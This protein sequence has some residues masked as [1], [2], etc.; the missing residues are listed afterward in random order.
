MK[1]YL[2]LL[3][4][5][6][7]AFSAKAQTSA[8]T[9]TALDSDAQYWCGGSVSV[10]FFPNPNFP[11]INQYYVNGVPLATAYPSLLQ[12]NNL[13]L[14]FGSG[15]NCTSTG[16]GAFAATV[17]DNSQITP[18]GSQWSFSVCALVTGQPCTQIITPVI[19]ASLDISTPIQNA[20]KAPRFNAI[21]G[22]YGYNDT[23]ALTQLIPGAT[24]FNILSSCQRYWNTGTGWVCNAGGGGSIGGGGTANYIPLF[25][26]TGVLLGNSPVSTDGTKLTTTQPYAFS[27]GTVAQSTL[28]NLDGSVT[29]YPEWFGAVGNGTTDDTTAF[30]DTIAACSGICTVQIAAKHYLLSQ[31][32]STP[33]NFRINGAGK[34][35]SELL[36]TSNTALNAGINIDTVSNVE[37]SNLSIVGSSSPATLARGIRV[38][39]ASNV[40]IHDNNISGGGYGATGVNPYSQ[41]HVNFSDNVRIQRNHLFNG[42]GTFTITSNYNNNG[43]VTTRLN[44]SNNV[45]EGNTEVISVG[46][47][48]CQRCSINGNIINQNNQ[49][50][51]TVNDGYAGMYYS[52]AHQTRNLT[53]LTGSGTITVSAAFVSGLTAFPPVGQLVLM[54]VSGVTGGTGTL[55]GLF[56]GV[57]TSSTSASFVSAGAN[58]SGANI[59]AATVT[60]PSG[61]NVAAGNQITNTGGTAIYLQTTFNTTVSSNSLTN[62]DQHEID[63]SLPAGCIGV[64]GPTYG[65][66]SGI[67]LSGNSIDGSGQHGIELASTTGVVISGGS[68]NNTFKNGIYLDS[69]N[70]NFT[71]GDVTLANNSSGVVIT[72][73]DSAGT[74]GA[75]TITNPLFDGLSDY[76]S[77]LVKDIVFGGPTLINCTPGQDGV[78]EVGTN[79]TMNNLKILGGCDI[80]L[81]GS[82]TKINHAEVY[83]YQGSYGAFSVRG[84]QHVRLTDIHA[85]APNAGT[86][87]NGISVIASGGVQSND[88]VVNGATFN[89]VQGS[90]FADGDEPA[91]FTGT[92]T[93]SSTE[94]DYTVLPSGYN[95][96]D[97]ITDASGYLPALTTLT[98]INTGCTTP[99]CFIVSHAATG[100][101]TEFTYL[102]ANH[103]SGTVINNMT[104]E[105][106]PG[107]QSCVLSFGSQ[108]ITFT[109]SSCSNYSNAG[110]QIRGVTT[111]AQAT[112]FTASGGSIPFDLAEQANH[113]V[114]QNSSFTNSS[115]FNMVD[116]TSNP[117]NVYLNNIAT[118]AGCT[119]G[120]AIWNTNAVSYGNIIGYGTGTPTAGC[121]STSAWNFYYQSSGAGRVVWICD[122]VSVA[123]KTFSV[124]STGVASINSNTGAFTFSFSA[125]AGSCSGT[126]CTFTGSGSGGGSV[127]NFIA[128]TGSWPSWLA[129]SV[130]TSTTTPTLSVTAS[131]IPFSALA[132]LSANQVLGAL[133]ATV[134]SGLTLPSCSGAG[135]AINYTLGSGFGCITT[136]AAGVTSYSGDG[137]LISNASSTG[138]VATTLYN[139]A[140]HR[141]WGNNTGSTGAPAYVAIGS[142]DLPSTI[143]SNTSGTASNL[144]GS[145]A[146]PAGT[147]GTTGTVGENDAKLATNAQVYNATNGLFLKKICSGTITLSGTIASGATA[148]VGSVSC[149]G[150]NAGDVVIAIFNGNIF[151]YGGF[152]PST[153]GILAIS[154]VS[155]SGTVTVNAEN[156]TTGSITIGTS[157]APVLNIIGVE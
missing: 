64:N 41:I 129:P 77:T 145:P 82:G 13:P 152:L 39:N 38:W 149:T 45:I 123:W 87:T 52:T 46:L 76:G 88:L 122:P 62:C 89:N 35:V 48:D 94:V 1:K 117:G 49:D 28:F 74:F 17:V 151:T 69:G 66:N 101:A 6:V 102:Y 91:G 154:M 119:V 100:S 73:T 33:S 80:Q 153:N 95:V 18:T 63:T 8:V 85:S 11:N 55:N 138:A 136:A 93:N 133:S 126:T 98:A 141:F 53:A 90:G 132:S 32:L 22:A 5:L 84:A 110:L 21:P 148:S 58:A 42:G 78:L 147:T 2:L 47:F 72:G 103:A 70:T 59:S 142:G 71:I 7:A 3:L 29:L 108:G 9:G 23:E 125:G 34:D 131:A 30:Q 137:S 44:V 105:G 56:E 54:Y 140:G 130:A 121:P 146:L 116:E 57:V 157:P 86:M 150:L 20:I 15:G 92:V 50:D 114:V 60:F 10:A 75:L 51:S 83:D 104:V 134:P 81:R 97:Y 43:P 124:L 113:V 16:R 65:G 37:I 79:V 155:T 99:P 112:N 19:G 96:G 106:A 36:Y 14:S 40:D 156:N 127:T 61:D 107:V 144:S 118:G 135:Q 115:C 111:G 67:V 24:Y 4:F 109:N 143:T 128:G 139:A 25:T 12:Q 68:I 31:Q 26:P 120:T 27:S